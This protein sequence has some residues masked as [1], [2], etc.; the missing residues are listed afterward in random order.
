MLRSRESAGA[1][2]RGLRSRSVWV[3]LPPWRGWG[4]RRPRHP[5]AGVGELGGAKWPQAGP[6]QECEAEQR[7]AQRVL[8]LVF[9]KRL[10]LSQGAFPLDEGGA[11]GASKDTDR[12]LLAIFLSLHFFKN[13]TGGNSLAPPPFYL[14]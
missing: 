5:Q 11:P 1:A 2:D 3:Q 6:A 9:L 14:R 8:F 4:S 10:P 7:S 12:P 13:S